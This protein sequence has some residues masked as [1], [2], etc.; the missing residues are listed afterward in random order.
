[1]DYCERCS[2]VLSLDVKCSAG[3]RK[4][5]VTSKDLVCSDP[6]VIPIGAGAGEEYGALIAK[7]GSGQ[8]CLLVRSR[9]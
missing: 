7:L 4:R 8:V 5:E 2:Y 6:G 9:L 3:E 1:M